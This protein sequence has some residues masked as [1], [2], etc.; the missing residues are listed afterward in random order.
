MDAFKN[1]AISALVAGGFYCANVKSARRAD[2]LAKLRETTFM[3]FVSTL[4]V[5]AFVHY[6]VPGAPSSEPAK[7]TA[8]ANAT[9]SASAS[10]NA[11]AKAGKRSGADPPARPG[12][13]R[14]NTLM[15][16]GGGWSGGLMSTGRG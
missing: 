12:G 14:R 6:M 16:G 8:S 7:A 10:A 5:V 15:G 4:A 13:A 2:R 3:V 9:A 1:V 11:S